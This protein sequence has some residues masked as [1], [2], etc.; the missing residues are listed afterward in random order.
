RLGCLVTQPGSVVASARSVKRTLA[1]IALGFEAIVM[2]L[3][4]LVFWGLG[5]LPPV[6][7]FGGG[8]VLCL[9]LVVTAGMLRH[10]WAYW[11][12]WVLQ[13]IILATSLF[14]VAML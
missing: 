2:F 9:A 4:A 13:G 10:V 3:A 8:G 5:A 12:G 14:N 7:A 11:I 1:S 6:V